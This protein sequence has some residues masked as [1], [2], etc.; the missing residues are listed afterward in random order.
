MDRP[1]VAIDDSSRYHLPERLPVLGFSFHGRTE[2]DDILD[3][4][5]TIWRETRKRPSAALATVGSERDSAVA[6]GDM[7]VTQTGTHSGMGTNVYICKHI[8]MHT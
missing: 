7:D 4:P 1:A 2:Q 5:V 6:A 3:D 8:L